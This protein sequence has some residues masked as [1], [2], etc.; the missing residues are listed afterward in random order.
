MNPKFHLKMLLG[1]CSFLLH[2]EIAPWSDTASSC[3][4]KLRSGIE[5]LPIK[6]R[7]R[8]PWCCG[9]SNDASKTTSGKSRSLFAP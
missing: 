7:K 9:T 3:T 6:L 1:W 8:P 5:Q 2:D 4:I